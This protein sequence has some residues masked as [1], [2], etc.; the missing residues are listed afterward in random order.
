MPFPEIH[1]DTAVV[2]KVLSGHRPPLSPETSMTGED[3]RPGW[4]L[5]S[6][7]WA[8]AIEDRP[9]VVQAID[10]LTDGLTAYPNV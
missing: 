1:K 9:T 6:N 10:F 4:K 8:H 2:M 7:G 5:A 3:Y